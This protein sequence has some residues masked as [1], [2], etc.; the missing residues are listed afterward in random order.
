MNDAGGNAVYRVDPASG[1][2]SLLA[3]IPTAGKLPG[4]EGLS[5]ADAERQPV[6]TGLALGDGVAFVGLLSE[7]WPQGRHRC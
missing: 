7:S 4:G 3:V 2:F 5:G 1:D 6:P